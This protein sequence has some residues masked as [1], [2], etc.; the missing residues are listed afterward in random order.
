M[1][2]IHK[3]IIFIALFALVGLYGCTSDFLDTN[4]L[5]V[6]SVDDFYQ[7]D[8]DAEQALMSCYNQ[9]QSTD[10][11]SLKSYLSDDIYAGGGMRG[12][13]AHWAEINEYQFG[14]SN[15]L[16]SGSFSA[17]YSG[18][19]L[20]N[21][22]VDNVQPESEIKIRAIAEAKVLRAYFYIDLVTLWGPAP[23]VLHELN[24][25][26]YAQPNSTVPE[27]W[28]QIEK[29]LTE[30][31]PNLPLKSVQGAAEKGRISKGTAQALLGKA[32]L[33]QEKYEQAATELSVVINSDEYSLYSDL[34][35]L[36]KKDAELGVESLFEIIYNTDLS[37]GEFTFA[38]W[39]GPRLLYFSPGNTG[40]APAWGFMSPQK[41]LYDAFVAA[42]DINRRKAAIMDEAEAAEMGA[43]LRDSEGNL[44]Y[45]SDG[46]IK[47]KYTTWISEANESNPWFLGTNI[48]VLRYADV[49]LMAAEAYNRSSS[50][51]DDR[52]REYVNLVRNRARLENITS[53]GTQLFDDIKAERRLELCFEHTRYQDLVRWRDALTVMA[54]QGHYIPLGDGTYFGNSN[55]GFKEKHKLLPFPETEINVNP[56]IVQNPGW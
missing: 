22:V 47:L 51:N 7:T 24:P 33:F 39:Y 28:A 37:T 36:M 6:T 8:E 48:R 49:L 54:E 38:G 3:N 56:N 26:E 4:Q 53:E 13:F 43:S 29:D 40:I 52:A 18:I 31:I 12:D 19:Y 11:L 1:K 32:Y 25:S 50:P 42:G 15:S 10:V 55:Y 14:T 2:K 34:S 41:G 27:L 46:Y 5:G 45:A 20:T 21:K 44:Q 17:L 16:I 30:A 23:L 35:T 9:L